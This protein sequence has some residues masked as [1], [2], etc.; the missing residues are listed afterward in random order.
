M[1]K[2]IVLAYSGGLD[3]SIAIGWL[4]ERGFRV[5]AYLGDVG[6]PMDKEKIKKKALNCGVEKVVIDDLKK[7][8]IE[9]YVMPALKANAVYEDKYFLATALSRPIIAKGMVEAAKKTGAGFVGH[10]CTGKGNDQVRFEMAVASLAPDLKVVAPAREWDFKSRE[11]QVLFAQK[12]NIPVEATKK[13][14]YSLDINLWGI[15]I[16][17]GVLEDPRVSPPEDAYIMTKDPLSASAKTKIVEI[18]FEKGIPVALNGKKTDKAALINELNKIGGE[19]GVGRSD[20]I[21]NR[22]V[23]IKSREIYEAPAAAALIFAHKEV[24]AMVL[25]R[26]TLH[27]KKQIEQKYSQLIYNGLWF[28]PLKEALDTFIDKT[29]EYVTGTIKLKLAK[30]NIIVLSRQSKFSLY[31]KELATYGQ[32]DTFD[33]TAAAGF[34][35]ISGLPYKLTGKRNK[36]R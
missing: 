35:A 8:F 25:D 34:I 31:S 23:G 10:G 29:Q 14:P 3:T 20:L 1:E 32:E 9:D 36:G 18:G 4:K 28:S 33:R 5:Y 22:F 13:K 21:E 17:C 2:K 7:E 6:Q 16:E 27:F 12:H 30:G 19:C 24:E 11:E 26:E 15:S